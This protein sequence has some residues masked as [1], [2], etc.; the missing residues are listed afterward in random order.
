MNFDFDISSVK[1]FKFAFQNFLTVPGVSHDEKIVDE[2]ATD[3]GRHS[4]IGMVP[5]EVVEFF[6]DEE[7]LS[8]E[9]PNKE[10]ISIRSNSPDTKTESINAKT[11]DISVED[12]SGSAFPENSSHV[13]I[14]KMVKAEYQHGDNDSNENYEQDNDD[15]VADYSTDDC[16]DDYSEHG[17]V[18]MDKKENTTH[19]RSET[20]SG[21]NSED[22]YSSNYE[23]DDYTDEETTD[24]EH[25]EDT[26]KKDSINKND[27]CSENIEGCQKTKTGTQENTDEEDFRYDDTD[28][29][30]SDG[31]SDKNISDTSSKIKETHTSQPDKDSISVTSHSSKSENISQTNNSTT[32]QLT[33]RAA[34][35]VSSLDTTKKSKRVPS[36]VSSKTNSFK[37]NEGKTDYSIQENKSYKKPDI[38]D[39]LKGDSKVNP[40]HSM[41][42]ESKI[43]DISRTANKNK[44]S[45][46][47]ISQDYDD[48]F[49]SDT[50]SNR[51]SSNVSHSSHDDTAS[52]FDKSS[53]NEDD[54]DEDCP[55]LSSTIEPK[56]QNTVSE[57]KNDKCTGDHPIA[58]NNTKY[59][60]NE[61]IVEPLHHETHKDAQPVTIKENNDVSSKPSFNVSVYDKSPDKKLAMT[62]NDELK[63]KVI[64]NGDNRDVDKLSARNEGIRPVSSRSERI[65]RTINNKTVN[66]DK[67]IL[68]KRSDSLPNKILKDRRPFSSHKKKSSLPKKASMDIKYEKTV[69]LLNTPLPSLNNNIGNIN[70][71]KNN[72]LSEN[73]NETRSTLNQ[74]ASL[75]AN[76]ETDIQN[77]ALKNSKDTVSVKS[78][79]HLRSE[80]SASK[81]N[82]PDMVLDGKMPSPVNDMK[83]LKYIPKENNKRI[84]INDF[85]KELVEIHNQSSREIDITVEEFDD[86]E[87]NDTR[88]RSSLEIRPQQPSDSIENKL[89]TESARLRNTYN[90]RSTGTQVKSFELMAKSKSNSAPVNNKR[91]SNISKKFETEPKEAAPNQYSISPT[92][93]L[94]NRGNDTSKSVTDKTNSN[95]YL[96][97]GNELIS[98]LASSEERK[99]EE[100]TFLAIKLNGDDIKHNDAQYFSAVSEES[101]GNMDADDDS[102]SLK[103][104][105][106]KKRPMHKN[107]YRSHTRPK[108]LSTNKLEDRSLKYGLDRPASPFIFNGSKAYVRQNSEINT[109]GINNEDSL[110]GDINDKR[111]SNTGLADLARLKDIRRQ[112]RLADEVNLDSACGNTESKQISDTS[113]TQN[114]QLELKTSHVST[115]SGN[116]LTFQCLK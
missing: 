48:D 70:R 49:D 36:A 94:T 47:D 103:Q 71:N 62:E 60:T 23:N 53:G 52:E 110:I 104:K 102:K 64:R 112:L 8:I 86:N 55:S 12:A 98:P 97:T 107:L 11:E 22:E 45:A 73:G 40:N 105:A 106:L 26:Q 39:T 25:N 9:L 20:L 44:T 43:L 116:K 90:R 83:Q 63:S 17:S 89:S 77:V 84:N 114:K 33:V 100:N 76:N 15:G 85:T 50:H 38:E 6:S 108:H 78:T 69:K 5:E 111:R 42:N 88:Y 68:R 46:D 2:T 34:D 16:H 18:D 66:V 37:T 35:S 41:A 57:N 30:T 65:T 14:N 80:L 4:R 96:I 72:R 32:S 87:I 10:V 75:C 56:I 79:E 59:K 21:H 29:E 7:E 58:S 101:E 3:A 67:K 82:V 1:Y 24:S 61:L 74:N 113:G 51:H 109:L 31:E 95:E 27:A 93:V 19:H 99:H 28:H 81:S 92:A 13:V 115:T 54:T 91:S